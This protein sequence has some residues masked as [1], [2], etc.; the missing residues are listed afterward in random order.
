MNANPNFTKWLG[1]FIRQRPRIAS[2]IAYGCVTAV[3][4]HFPW[5]SDVRW[6][7]NAAFLTTAGSLTYAIA[8]AITAPRLITP[9]QI[10]GSFTAC[11]V[12][13]GTSLLGVALFAPLLT[14]W[15]WIGNA[16]SQGWFSLLGMTLLIALFSFLAVGWALLL[17]S[18]FLGWG[19]YCLARVA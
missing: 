19:L 11:L 16:G 12:G 7:G 1:L 6:S 13:A 5:R 9:T 15:V 2:A 18:T 4:I 17:V 14:T 8:G 3:V 10:H